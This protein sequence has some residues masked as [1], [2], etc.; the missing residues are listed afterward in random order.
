[1]NATPPVPITPISTS[2]A[3]PQIRPLFETLQTHDGPLSG[4]I[5]SRRNFGERTAS[6]PA[7]GSIARSTKLFEDGLVHRAG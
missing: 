6:A 1:M 2:P 4:L 7:A 3:S 5:R